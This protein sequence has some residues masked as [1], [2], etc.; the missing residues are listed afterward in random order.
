VKVELASLLCTVPQ[1]GLQ[2]IACKL[3][4][5][6][7]CNIFWHTEKYLQCFHA[8]HVTGNWLYLHSYCGCVQLLAQA[9]VI[10]QEA[11]QHIDRELA[12]KLPR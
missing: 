11:A 9:A 7:V 10:Q 3:V 2:T 8:L 1:A 4:T 12:L 5:G 6:E